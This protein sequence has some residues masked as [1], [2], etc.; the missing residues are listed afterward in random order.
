MNHLFMKNMGIR[1]NITVSFHR[2][3]SFCVN[4]IPIERNRETSCILFSYSLARKK[5]ISFVFVT[6]GNFSSLAIIILHFL[7]SFNPFGVSFKKP[8]NLH[9]SYKQDASFVYV[10]GYS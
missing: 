8:F 5:E 10:N 6:Q 7:G 9:Y 4:D 3:N 1:L 2:L